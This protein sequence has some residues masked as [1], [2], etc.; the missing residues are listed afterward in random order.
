MTDISNYNFHDATLIDITYNWKQKQASCSLL[1]FLNG[2][3]SDAI[4]CQI[5]FSDV[6]SLQ[7]PH[8]S[9][10]GESDTVATISQKEQTVTIEMQ[11]GD[12]IIITAKQYSINS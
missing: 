9:P 6:T 1:A 5:Q 8:Q 7:I 2:T 11:S 10:W 3:N 12:N 4:P